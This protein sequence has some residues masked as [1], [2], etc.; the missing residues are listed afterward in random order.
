VLSLVIAA[1]A[2]IRFASG[3]LRRP[4]MAAFRG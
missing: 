4:A 3:A 2:A 1:A